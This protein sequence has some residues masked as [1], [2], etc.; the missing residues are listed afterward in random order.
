MKPLLFFTLAAVA[1]EV[2]KLPENS[3]IE[4]KNRIT[5]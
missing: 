1:F 5:D 2:T 3:N 4:M